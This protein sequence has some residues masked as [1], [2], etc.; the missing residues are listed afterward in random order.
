MLPRVPGKSV[1]DSEQALVPYDPKGPDHAA[2]FVLPTEVR[3]C[4]PANLGSADCGQVCRGRDGSDYV[5]K[6][7]KA[8]GSKPVTPHCEWFCTELGESVGIGSPPCKVI[9]HPDKTLVF[10]SR[11]E[12]GVVRPSPISGPWW[13]KVKAGD[14]R[15]DDL[16]ASLSRIYAFDHFIHNV[17]RHLGN[18]IVR[19]QHTGHVVLA[20]DYSRSWI[21]N[22]FP[23][24]ALPMQSG[25]TVATQR[26]L[27]ALWG[28][29]YIDCDEVAA[30]IHELSAL[31]KPIIERIIGRHPEEWLDE[32]MKTAILDWWGSSS[33]TNRL[34][35]IVRGVKDGTYL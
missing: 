28:T 9:R 26:S 31:G 6:D 14:I 4:H 13:Q 8:G 3:W 34:N 30:V 5:I 29:T 21:W 1:G 35:G 17:D 32:C 20:M 2:L 10:G 27:A 7:A 23:L 11:W 18:F 12:G 16:R 19:D 25:N 15:L 22:G 24:P 33:M